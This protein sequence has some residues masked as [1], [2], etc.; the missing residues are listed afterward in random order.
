MAARISVPTFSLGRMKK[1]EVTGMI[2]ER[3]DRRRTFK[4]GQTESLTE[5]IF[6][7][8]EPWRSRFL[9]WLSERANGGCGARLP[10]QRQVAVWLDDSAL[11]REVAVLLNKWLGKT[12]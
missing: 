7:L 1:K 12:L 6:S 5:V 4:R 11:S 9:V 10:S 3:L 2:K 8:E